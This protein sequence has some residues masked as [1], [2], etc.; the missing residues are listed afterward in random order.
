M[1][2]PRSAPSLTI[3]EC[4]SASTQRIRAAATCSC[5][6]ATEAG[7]ARNSG[8]GGTSTRLRG[9]GAELGPAVHQHQARGPWQQLER[10]VERRVTT[11]E[12]HQMLARQ[13]GRALHPGLDGGALERVRAL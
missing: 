8:R 1:L 4:G 9:R 11:T 10:P 5:I 12:D 2:T 3:S 6:R 13:L 7:A